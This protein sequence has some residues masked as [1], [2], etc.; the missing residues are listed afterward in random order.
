MFSILDLKVQ[1]K[2]GSRGCAEPRS[3]KSNQHETR[4]VEGCQTPIFAGG[5][6]FARDKT[7][8]S[9]SL[10]M[11]I[12]DWCKNRAKRLIPKYYREEYTEDSRSVQSTYAAARDGCRICSLLCAGLTT[13]VGELELELESQNYEILTTLVP[14]LDSRTFTISFRYS[15]EGEVAKRFEFCSPSGN[16]VGTFLA[17]ICLISSHRTV[18]G[19]GLG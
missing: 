14:S 7:P 11:H 17:I 3:R 13:I 2:R 8:T 9:S 19:V 5:H 15:R 18:F 6:P 12:C 10:V 4:L 1:Q 16:D